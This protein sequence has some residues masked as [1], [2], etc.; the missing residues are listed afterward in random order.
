MFKNWNW[1]CYITQTIYN[2][3]CWHWQSLLLLYIDG[4]LRLFLDSTP[5]QRTHASL[6]AACFLIALT[7]FP[8]CGEVLWKWVLLRCRDTKRYLDAQWHLPFYWINLQDQVNRKTMVKLL[9]SDG[10]LLENLSQNWNH[11]LIIDIVSVIMDCG[12]FVLTMIVS[13]LQNIHGFRNVQAIEFQN[14][15]FG[16]RW[17]L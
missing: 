13:L 12:L 7:N 16:Y 11:T 14:L 1:S 2:N 4:S 3:S 17:G 6:H 9:L 8:N 10:W 15:K 5:S